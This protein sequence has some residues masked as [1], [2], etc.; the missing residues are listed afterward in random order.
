MLLTRRHVQLGL[1]CLWLVDAALQFQPYMFSRSF[2]PQVIASA[3]DGQPGWVSAGVRWAAHLMASAPGPTN[4]VFAL[5]Q[6]MIAAA[7]LW[8]PRARLGLMASIPW[9]VSV[10]YFGEGL[11]GIASGHATLIT[12]APGSALLYAVLALFAWPHGGSLR[13]AGN[14]GVAVSRIVLPVWTTFWVGGA[15]LQLLPGQNSAGSIADSVNGSAADAPRW[16][17]GADGAVGRFVAAA[18]AGVVVALVVVLL[19]IGTLALTRSTVARW[20]IAAGMV[21]ATAFWLFGQSLG[22]INTG[23]STDPNAGPLV[24][25]LAVALL[26][27]NVR[28]MPDRQ[29]RSLKPVKLMSHPTTPFAV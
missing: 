5:V 10:W 9:A 17:T 19:L 15:V 8:R 18:G 26:S 24:T 11:G 14:S 28:S 20:A 13:H 25:L 29:A 6:L 27:A 22:A 23:M 7:I 1:G 3:A 16:L 2:P 12:G 21:L 4:A